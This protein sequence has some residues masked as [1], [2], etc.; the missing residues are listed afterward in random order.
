MRE[1]RRFL[2]CCHCRVETR[3]RGLREPA[4]AGFQRR[5]S[6][7][8]V[9]LV[10]EFLRARCARAVR[11]A[12]FT[13]RHQGKPHCA[14]T[15][16]VGEQSSMTRSIPSIA[17]CFLDAVD[18]YANPRA[19]MYRTAASLSAGVW[20]SIS[21]EE[22][23]RR[24]AGLAT[25]ARRTGDSSSG[26]RVAHVCAELSRMAHRGFCDSGMGAVTVPVYFNESADRLS[27]ILN[28]SGARIVITVGRIAGA[29][30][31]G[32]PRAIAGTRARDFRVATA[33]GFATA[34][35]CATR[36]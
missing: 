33:S 9:T 31:R 30:N 14:A 24:V 16:A 26:D 4:C 2:P 10:L 3:F 23:L 18:R 35:S 6:A 22:M 8:R 7:A 12:R 29:K 28:D 13:G 20:E 21:G 15:L 34:K 5:G 19:Q 36:R 17:K 27:Y 11:W 25:G 1:L 32:V